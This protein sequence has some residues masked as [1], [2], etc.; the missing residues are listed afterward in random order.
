MWRSAMALRR[1]SRSVPRTAP[2]QN[3]GLRDYGPGR[4]VCTRVSWL[5]DCTG[6]P[7]TS[8]RDWALPETTGN[9]GPA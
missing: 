8:R 1:P 9:A 2:V 7:A 4:I 6:R 5:A 3:P